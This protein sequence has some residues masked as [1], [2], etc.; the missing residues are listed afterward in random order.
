MASDPEGDSLTF[1][2]EDSSSSQDEGL[3]QID[4]ATGAV[5]FKTAPNF[6]IPTDIDSNNSLTFTVVA[7]D[8]SLSSSKRFFANITDVAEAPTNISISNNSV[9]ENS[10]GALFGV[11][12]ITDEDPNIMEISITDLDGGHFTLD[13]DLNLSLQSGISADYEHKSSYLIEI[14]LIDNGGLTLVD[15]LTL[16]ITDV[17]EAPTDINLTNG[18]VAENSSGASFGTLSTTDPDNSDTFTYS[19]TGG[20]DASSFEIGSNNNLKFKSGVAANFEAQTEYSVTVTTTDSGSKTYS[21]T[22]TVGIANANEA[23]SFTTST[24]STIAENGTAVLT[25]VASDPENGPL[26]YSLGSGNDSGKFSITA[27]G[28]LTFNRA[29]DYEIP[30]DLNENNVY[31]VNVLVSDGTFSTTFVHHV[32]VTDVTEASALETPEAVQTVETK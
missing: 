6:E 27:A 28:V 25:V 13:K 18:T 17:N 30:T 1:S 24:T 14:T 2:F 10:P 19:V 7:S 5:S 29:P 8:G 20:T 31:L 16:N 21:K 26:T 22:F 23:P 15:T 3:L 4:S 11:L 12:N 32:Y 9:P